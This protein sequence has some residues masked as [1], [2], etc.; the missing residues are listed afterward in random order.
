[1]AAALQTF[2]TRAD[3]CQAPAVTTVTWRS[4]SHR[5]L[6]MSKSFACCWMRTKTE[7]DNPVRYRSHWFPLHQ[8][9]LAG[10]LQTCPAARRAHSTGGKTEIEAF[11]R[12]CRE[13][14]QTRTNSSPPVLIRAQ[15]LRGRPKTAELT[16]QM[17][18]IWRMPE[19]KQSALPNFPERARIRDM[20]ANTL[21]GT[22]PLPIDR[23][24]GLNH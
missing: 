5:S 10:H 3:C 15:F 24:M 19:Q 12:S 11:A 7:T 22:M 8:P 16:T 21:L 1:V 9:A 17:P 6:V 14:I 13:G 23:A 2:R 4:P 20:P 18:A